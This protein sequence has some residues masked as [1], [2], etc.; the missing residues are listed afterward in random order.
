MLYLAKR[1]HT[2]TGE[3]WRV[4]LFGRNNVY[5]FQF[6]FIVEISYV[7]NDDKCGNFLLLPWA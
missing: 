7:L 2:V 5:G 3:L 6:L 4:I 1:M